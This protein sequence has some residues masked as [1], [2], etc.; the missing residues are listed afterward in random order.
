MLKEK[1]L[2]TRG[3]GNFAWAAG[4]NASAYSDECRVRYTPSQRARAETFVDIVR[5]GYVSKD[6][7][8]NYRKKFVQIY[9]Q[10]GEVKDRKLAREIDLICEERNYEKV[11]TEQGVSFRIKF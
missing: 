5:L 10:A 4:R 2:N 11:R 1:E 8:I 7:F 6:I 3:A 9:V